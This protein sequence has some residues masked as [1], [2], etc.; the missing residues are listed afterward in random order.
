MGMLN[1]PDAVAQFNA[2]KQHWGHELVIVS[3]GDLRQPDNMALECE[4]CHEVLFDVDAPEIAE[5]EHAS[6]S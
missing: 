3:Y 4:T 5:A 6:A 2:L 1:V